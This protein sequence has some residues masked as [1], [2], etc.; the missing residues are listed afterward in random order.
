MSITNSSSSSNNNT[1]NDESEKD[2]VMMMMMN[3]SDTAGGATSNGS[4]CTAWSS[5]SSATA[6]RPAP[7]TRIPVDRQWLQKLVAKYDD[8]AKQQLQH[9]N[10]AS[11]TAK[12]E[13]S[14]CGSNNSCKTSSGRDDAADP[15]WVLAPMVDQSDLPFR[16]LARRYGVKL[17]FTPMIHCKLYTTCH[18]YKR[19]FTLKNIPASLDRPLIAQICGSDLDSVLET[20]RDLEPY[21][22]GIDINCGWYVYVS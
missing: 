13:G 19:T 5:R 16:L 22:D 6:A 1:N 20:C 17:C 9:N 10:N 7:G 18:V 2:A 4:R 14:C 15:L 3:S 11:S 8:S 12:E 21:C